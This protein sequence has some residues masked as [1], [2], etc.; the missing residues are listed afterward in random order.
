[1]RMLVFLMCL[2]RAVYRIFGVCDNDNVSSL[3]TVLGLH[4]ISNMVKNR[5]AKF[6]EGL[7]ILLVPR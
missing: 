4:G 2:D 6:L 3:R 5:H 7:L 1:M